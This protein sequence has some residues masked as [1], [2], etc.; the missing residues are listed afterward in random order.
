[1][2]FFEK[3]KGW[4]LIAL[5]FSAIASLLTSVPAFVVVATEGN[6]K[7]SSLIIQI[8]ASLGTFIL[9]LICGTIIGR[10]MVKRFR[11]ELKGGKKLF[12]P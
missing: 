1:M 10:K 4:I 7:Q 3:V 6:I 11:N 5:C 9:V 12:D 2:K 8:V